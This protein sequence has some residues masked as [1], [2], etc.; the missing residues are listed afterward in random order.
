MPILL[1]E[2]LALLGRLDLPTDGV[3]DY[4][5]Q[6]SA[7]FGRRGECLDI[8][9][10]RWENKG[11][12]ATIG[13][14]WKDSKKWRGRWVLFQ[15]TALSWSR[16]GFP[17]GALAAIQILKLRGAKVCIVFH[18]IR[19]DQARGWKQRTRVAFQY[20]TMR[21]A[22]RWAARCILTV[23][24]AQVPWL[25]R[26]SAKAAFI[27]VG[28][29]VPET[30]RQEGNRGAEL[31]GVPTVAL[32]GVTEGA[33]GN[34]ESEDISYVARY[35][36][37]KTARLRL[38]I[39]GRGSLEAEAILRKDLD[40][41]GVEVS[42]LGVMPPEQIG[43]NLAKA[44][45][46]LCIRGHISSRRGS[47]IAGIACGLPIVGY[48]GEETAFPITAA[49]VLLIDKGGRDGVAEALYRVLSDEKLREDLRQRS[50]AAEREYFSWGAIAAQFL[51]ALSDG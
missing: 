35:V 23:P 5:V 17:V 26:N 44:D 29:N 16:R 8:A 34:S 30:S 47:A 41:S 45:V 38:L 9:E 33:K 1:P 42:V 40:G 15:Y 46:L 39:M 28:S 18:D 32:F 31:R 22:F 20:G 6:L 13:Q 12:L 19:Y 43:E 51:R 21:T 10:V 49:G 2:P 3:R 48:R 27:P 4:C 7:A 37:S 24:A 25:P 14:L 11:W 36:I 50:L